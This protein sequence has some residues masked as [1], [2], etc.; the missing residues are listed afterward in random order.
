MISHI[1]CSC[2]P[3]GGNLF[4][5]VERAVAHLSDNKSRINMLRSLLAAGWHVPLASL[6]PI[7]M[8]AQRLG[9]ARWARWWP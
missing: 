3:D 1:L 9:L 5:V 4:G 8:P 7:C 2:Q 6:H